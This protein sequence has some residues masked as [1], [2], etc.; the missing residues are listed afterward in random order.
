MA[1]GQQFFDWSAAYRLFSKARFDIG[2][3]FAVARRAVVEQLPADQPFI[4]MLDDTLLRKR[5]RKIAGTSWHRDPL[6]P[7]FCNNFIWAQ[8]FLQISAALP[9]SPGRR[10]QKRIGNSINSKAGKAGSACAGPNV[11]LTYALALTKTINA[12]AP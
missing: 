6:G 11:S 3:L 9:E 4:A 5:G 1:S 8:R 12:N 2:G 10:P 7:H